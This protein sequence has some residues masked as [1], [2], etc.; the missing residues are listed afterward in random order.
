MSVLIYGK[1]KLEK[2]FVVSLLNQTCKNFEVIIVDGGNPSDFETQNLEG[3]NCV[4]VRD[5]NQGISYNGRNKGLYRSS[6]ELIFCLD[7]DTPLVDT[8]IEDLLANAKFLRSYMS[9][10]Y[11]EDNEDV[12]VDAYV[13]KEGVLFSKKTF[14]MYGSFDN[15]VKDDVADYLKRIEKKGGKVEYV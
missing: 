8:Y 9:E 5:V 14:L 2:A 3:L 13:T 1:K 6:S 4:M 11:Y 12:L 10:L 7:T 15:E